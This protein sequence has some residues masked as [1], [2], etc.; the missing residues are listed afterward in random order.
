M[1]NDNEW[2]DVEI[3]RGEFIGWGEIGQ[4]V[5][6]YV[7]SYSDTDGSDFND[8]P[9]PQVVLELTEKAISF[10]DKGTSKNT[11]D[12]GEFVTVT[13]GQA[14]LKRAIKAAALEVGNLVRIT[15]DSEYKT[16]KGMGKSF[17]V[18]VNRS[19]RPSSSVSSSD[20]V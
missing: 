13:C 17:K 12:A 9:C 11:I 5:T 6:G 4:R 16:G 3:P 18:Q 20:L 8:E 1:S 15:F 10:R 2:I 7:V 19:A 14:N